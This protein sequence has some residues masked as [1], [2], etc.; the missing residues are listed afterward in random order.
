MRDNDSKNGLPIEG[1]D[2]AIEP[3]ARGPRDPLYWLESKGRD[4]IQVADYCLQPGILKDSDTEQMRR[5]R[6]EIE[7]T[8]NVLLRDPANIMFWLKLVEHARMIGLLEPASTKGAQELVKE[9]RTQNMRTSKANKP[10]GVA[11]KE[12]I[13]RAL[14]SRPKW[15]ETGAH[16]TASAIEPTINEALTRAGFKPIGLAAIYKRLRRMASSPT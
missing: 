6:Q 7:S 12:A 16:A 1:S 13:V 15:K 2:R 14:K 3:E 4:L 5:L 11:I 8:V 9:R 10:N